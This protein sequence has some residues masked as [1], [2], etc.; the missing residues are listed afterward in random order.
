MC[1]FFF[2]QTWN[3]PEEKTMNYF[4]TMRER[5][6]HLNVEDSYNRA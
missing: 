6:L 5:K 1:V 4:I 2:W 3:K